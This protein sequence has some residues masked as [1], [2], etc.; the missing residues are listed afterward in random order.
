MQ[1]E[2]KI[3]GKY[4]DTD[5]KQRLCCEDCSA[6]YNSR[7]YQYQKASEK[8]RATYYDPQIIERDCE[9]CGKHFK[10]ISKLLFSVTD[11]DNRKHV[12]CSQS[13]KEDYKRAHATCDE[14]GCP[15]ADKPY[16]SVDH[17]HFC[18]EECRSVYAR[19]M[20]IKNGNLHICSQCGREFI[21]KSGT[22]CSKECSKNALNTGWRTEKSPGEP[23]IVQVEEHCPV[24]M[25]THTVNYPSGKVRTNPL[26]ACCSEKCKTKYGSFLE[27]KKKKESSDIT[28]TLQKAREDRQ[29]PSEALCTTCKVPYKQCERMQSNFRILPE[30]AHYN[31][32]G[33]LTI[34]P[35]Y[36]K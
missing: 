31:K 22:F 36:K 33:V 27:R 10:T 24:C 2:C 12:F 21:R 6:H 16:S 20:A 17:Y 26:D 32:D 7:R 34:C 35:K 9:V 28:K 25:T 18:S 8:N 11:D 30:G 14:C 3:C 5:N 13:C 15:L 23:K 1:K 4:F 29:K 19:K